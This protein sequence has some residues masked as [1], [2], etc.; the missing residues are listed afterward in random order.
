[1]PQGILPVPDGRQAVADANR[2]F[3]FFILRGEFRVHVLKVS[4][5]LFELVFQVEKLPNQLMTL[6]ADL[7]HPILTP[8]AQLLEV[9]VVNL[10]G[11]L[12]MLH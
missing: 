9:T 6:K 2:I 5:R 8:L 10:L 11:L 12:Q 7:I 3:P 4:D 1:M